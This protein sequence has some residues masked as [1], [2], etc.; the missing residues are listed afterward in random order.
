MYKCSL[1]AVWPKDF[2]LAAEGIAGSEQSRQTSRLL[3]VLE[4]T[5]GWALLRYSELSAV[6]RPRSQWLRVEHLNVQYKCKII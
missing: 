5:G 2:P 4:R 6:K 3:S 1:K